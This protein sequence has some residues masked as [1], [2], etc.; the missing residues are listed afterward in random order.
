MNILEIFRMDKDSIMTKY[1]QYRSFGEAYV[2][3][4]F[5]KELKREGKLDEIS[6][7]IASLRR[8]ENLLLETISYNPNN[9]Y[10]FL[11]NSC[12]KSKITISNFFDKSFCV[13]KNIRIEIND[14]IFR[15][16]EG[17]SHINYHFSIVDQDNVEYKSYKLFSETGE[18]IDGVFSSSQERF[19]LIVNFAVTGDFNGN[20]YKIVI[21][22]TNFEDEN[23]FI[24]SE[25]KICTKYMKAKIVGFN[26]Q[27]EGLH[28]QRNVFYKDVGGKDAHL[29][30]I[31]SCYSYDDTKINCG[32]TFFIFNVKACTLLGEPYNDIKYM[33]GKLL[34]N[35]NILGNYNSD[36]F[37]Y[38]FNFRPGKIT[39]N[40]K[41]YLIVSKPEDIQSVET[42]QFEVKS[43]LNH[44][45]KQ[46]M[47]NKERE[48]IMDEERVR[49]ILNHHSNSSNSLQAYPAPSNSSNFQSGILSSAPSFIQNPQIPQ[50]QLSITNN[51]N[52][53]QASSHQ[54]PSRP[55]QPVSSSSKQFESSISLLR[56]ETFYKKPEKDRLSVLVDALND[57]DERPAKVQ[58]TDTSNDDVSI[59]TIFREVSSLNQS[60]TNLLHYISAFNQNPDIAFESENVEKCNNT[61]KRLLPFLLK[62][63]KK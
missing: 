41:L 31:I 55:S 38:H 24:S 9:R 11:L 33:S 10:E 5:I 37:T 40:N 26:P 1:S 15:D 35:G 8:L 13:N 48:R 56:P 58:R 47:I 16:F 62:L 39:G 42:V 12:K 30:C 46:R 17:I 54:I 60:V 14:S 22:K 63:Q 21:K 18:I 59:Q 44:H 3:N 51:Q 45:T 32:E 27:I 25:F 50:V 52:F 53:I 43:K 23:D 28:P 6:S 61:V 49:E 29:R 2:Y 34:Q 20:I 36:D 19:A 57:E 4:K 7:K